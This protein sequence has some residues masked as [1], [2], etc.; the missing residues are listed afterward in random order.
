MS[1]S[2]SH[3]QIDG[4]LHG[5]SDGDTQLLT[6]QCEPSNAT[7]QMPDDPPKPENGG[8]DAAG[9]AT[10]AGDVGQ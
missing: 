10:G 6:D 2:L 1:N 7:H 4:L 3:T 9:V 5:G 8:A